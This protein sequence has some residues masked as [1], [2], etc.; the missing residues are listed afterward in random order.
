[1]RKLY[2]TEIDLINLLLS[3]VK[4]SFKLPSNFHDLNVIDLKDGGMGSI[5]F[6]C[7]NI[8]TRSFDKAI[9]EAIAYDIDG[10][11]VMLEISIDSNGYLY[12]LD[13][14]TED[15]SQLKAPLGTNLKITNFNS[16]PYVE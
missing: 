13:A 4:I 5:E 8:N 14:F 1:M 2:K 3:K 10:R 15:F 16:P 6:V 11:K 7:N 9:L 12:Q